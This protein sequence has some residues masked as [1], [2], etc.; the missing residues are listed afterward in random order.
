M[1]GLEHELKINM[2]EKSPPIDCLMLLLNWLKKF[3]FQA[4][5]IQVIDIDK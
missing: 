5:G 3:I 1:Q 2:H 4:T